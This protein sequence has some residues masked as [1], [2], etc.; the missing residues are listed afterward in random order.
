M[1]TADPNRY[2]AGPLRDRV[3]QPEGFTMVELLVAMM[4]I[5]VILAAIFSV[6]FGLQRTYAFTEDDLKAQRE[7]RAALSE[8]VELIRT[9]RQ[10]D[11][12]SVPSTLRNLVIVRAEPNVLICYTDVDRDPDHLLE[13]VRFRVDTATRTLYRDT[14][15]E[16]T[17]D[18]TFG[19]ADS[20]RLVGQWIS[21]DDDDPL[22]TYTGMNGASLEWSTD[23]VT[24]ALYVMDTSQIREVKI[25]LLVD[26]IKDEAPIRHELASV[27]QPR[28]LRQY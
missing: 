11:P 17:N 15:T 25:R 7:A 27:V 20:I 10:P 24:G 1:R 21:N 5:M 3:S 19:S 2:K 12:T 8:M 9:A 16:H 6:W 28:N 4:L 18:P 14:D 23:P 13:L 22:F 26:V